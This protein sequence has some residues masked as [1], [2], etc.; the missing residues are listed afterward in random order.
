MINFAVLLRIE[1]ETKILAQL[2]SAVVLDTPDLDFDI[3]FEQGINLAHV[4]PISHIK[5]L[6]C[7]V[8]VW[9]PK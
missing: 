5:E 4:L 7:D 3:D 6:H 9:A 2:C 1:S 8:K